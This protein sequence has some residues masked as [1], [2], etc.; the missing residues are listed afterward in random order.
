MIRRPPRSTR[1]DTLFPY[2]TLFRS[3]LPAAIADFD[4]SFEVK[5]PAPSLL[6]LI[7][8]LRLRHRTATHRAR[9][10]DGSAEHIGSAIVALRTRP[11]LAIAADEQPTR[12][13]RQRILK[14]FDFIDRHGRAEDN[15]ERL[16]F[17]LHD[18]KMVG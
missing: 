6:L 14:V 17:V 4:L 15:E 9:L 7:R 16:L 2:P 18:W 1:T 8:S 13:R 12:L 3:T 5:S 11:R 10:V